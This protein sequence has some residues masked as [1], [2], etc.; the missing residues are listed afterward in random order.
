MKSSILSTLL[1]IAGGLISLSSLGQTAIE[2]NTSQDSLR[3][4]NGPGRS[5]W[6]LIQ[7]EIN[8]KPDYNSKSIEGSV[9]IS[10]LDKGVK[11]M[12][13]DLQE[14]LMI[15]SINWLSKNDAW[16]LTFKREGNV[17]WVK[18]EKTKNDFN[19][20]KK[21]IIYYHGYPRVAVN[22]PWDGGWVFTKD[23]EGNPWMSVACQGIGASVW[24]PC[25]DS[26]ADEPDSGALLNIIVPDS[27]IAVGNGKL[28]NTKKLQGSLKQYCWQVKNP[29]NNYDIIPYI[30][31]Y[32][33][34]SETY[35][36]EKGMLDLDYWVLDY[37]K[38][39][40]IEQFKEVPK[41]LK[42]FEYWFGPYPFY[43]DG[44]KLVEAPYLG[45]E[46]QSAVAYG[47]NY[48][49]GYDGLDRSMSG[50]G[51]RWD[52][53][54][55][56]ES[57]HEW[58]GNSITSADIADLWVHEGFT[59]YSEVLYIE[60]YWGKEDANKY[61][62]GT[63]QTIDNVSP[64]IGSYGIQDDPSSR[65]GDM[66]C[67]AANMIH[68]IRQVVNDDEKFR[69]MLR[70]MNRQF[71]HSIVTSTAIEDFICKELGIS[72]T[73]F[74]QYL[75]TTNRPI[76]EYEINGQYLNYRWTNT[77]TGFNMPI[78]ISTD[79]KQLRISPSDKWK[80]IKI[81]KETNNIIKT[82]P[83]YYIQLNRITTIEEKN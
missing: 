19:P 22:A 10:Y 46:H 56:H 74:N 53:I 51:M 67:K 2:K 54:I 6:D 73:I 27:L 35:K 81:G 15:D 78:D 5:T 30:G 41:M 39:K 65:T 37:N 40:A 72:N 71:Y 55:I 59:S 34:F 68:T 62:I 24:F 64:I 18:T 52:F 23:K 25:K 43:E 20:F 16:P 36:G 12:Q 57:G 29:I 75:R 32:I 31:K 7:Y 45:M 38:E 80:R 49:M 58:F 44:Y 69:N 63:R 50:V 21:I 83:N 26:Q 66:Y 28:I 4:G 76:L 9:A 17:Y 13:L 70:K 60:S 8:V 61:A 42:S 1:I 14:P 47:N 33:H 3:G 48:K 82:N 77:V 11:Y 79:S